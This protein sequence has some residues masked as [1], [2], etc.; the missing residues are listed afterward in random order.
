MTKQEATNRTF[1]FL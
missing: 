1:Q